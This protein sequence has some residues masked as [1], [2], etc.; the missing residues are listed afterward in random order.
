MRPRILR[1]HCR[2]GHELTDDNLVCCKLPRR[3]CKACARI[4]QARSNARDRSVT[5]PREKRCRSGRHL[6]EGQNRSP[7][8]AC[9]VCASEYQRDYYRRMRA[10]RVVIPIDRELDPG[11]QSIEVTIPVTPANRIRSNEE[12]IEIELRA[13]RRQGYEVDLYVQGSWRQKGSRQRVV[14][15]ERTPLGDEWKKGKNEL[16]G[17][18]RIASAVLSPA[19]SMVPPPQVVLRGVRRIQP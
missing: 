7:S 14:K 17:A 10:P 4:S 2:H 15:L 16:V 8:G 18:V 6:I 13:L 12:R 3:I 9:R 1:T 11:E 5:A 19:Y